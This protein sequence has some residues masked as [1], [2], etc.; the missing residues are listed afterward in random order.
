MK[1]TGPTLKADSNTIAI[2]SIELAH[3]GI[4]YVK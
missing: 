2:E 3:Q 1:W 4:Y